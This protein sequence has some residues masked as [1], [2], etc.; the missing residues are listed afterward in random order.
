MFQSETSKLQ[1]QATVNGL[2]SQ[3]LGSENK[4]AS[5][6][7]SA[8]QK[9]SSISCN[10]DTKSIKKQKQQRRKEIRQKSKQREEKARKAM[11][12]MLRSEKRYSDEQLT[13]ILERNVSAAEVHD[14]EDLQE[15]K[16]NILKQRNLKQAAKKRVSNKAAKKQDF[17]TKIAKGQISYPGLTPG[18]APVGESDDEP[19]SSDDE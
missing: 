1:S 11:I 9:I 10:V 7:I 12:Q 17:N 15:L 5:R 8:T 16:L 3:F 18:L 13:K 19:S 4:K 2:L 6:S 14:T